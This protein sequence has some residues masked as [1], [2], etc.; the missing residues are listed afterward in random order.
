MIVLSDHFPREI[1][2]ELAREKIK[3]LKITKVPVI[4]KINENEGVDGDGIHIDEAVGV[5]GEIC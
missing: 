4:I 3:V 2:Q 1:N 5:Y